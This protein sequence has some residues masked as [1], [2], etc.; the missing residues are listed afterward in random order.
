MCDFQDGVHFYERRNL[1]Y[2]ISL[3]CSFTKRT[4]EVRG[5][6]L[7]LDWCEGAAAAARLAALLVIPCED[8]GWALT[9]APGARQKSQNCAYVNKKLLAG[10][11][12]NYLNHIH[13]Y[14]AEFFP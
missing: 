2:L 11:K 8:D 12:F 14:S 10:Y 5:C 1:H 6:R 13:L 4:R 7:C 9:P 3:D